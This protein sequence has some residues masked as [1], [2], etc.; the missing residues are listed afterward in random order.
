MRCAVKNLNARGTKRVRIS[1][2]D[3]STD[4]HGQISSD[5][6]RRAPDR[7]RDTGCAMGGVP[8]DVNLLGDPTARYALAEL[9]PSAF[10]WIGSTVKLARPR[11]RIAAL[12]AGD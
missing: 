4:V 6:M 10:G 11:R 12:A 1:E 9:N 5:K 7:G 3:S 2:N 8:E